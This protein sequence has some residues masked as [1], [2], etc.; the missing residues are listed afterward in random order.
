M[1]PLT[2][3]RLKREIDKYVENGGDFD[4]NVKE[5]LYYFMMFRVMQDLIGV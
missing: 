3:E 2:M 1:L 4:D 5:R